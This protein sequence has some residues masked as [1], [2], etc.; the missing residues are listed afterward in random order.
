MSLAD[1]QPRLGKPVRWL[2]SRIWWLEHAFERARAAGRAEDDTRLRIFFVLALFAAGFLTLG[3]GAVH[4]ALFSDALHTSGYVAEQGAR[5]D[6]VDRNGNLLAVDLLHYGLFLDPKEIWDKNETRAALT[7]A[8]PGVT[9]DRLEKILAGERRTRLVGGLTPDDRTRINDLGLPGVSFEEEQAR[10]YP[11][12]ST[13]SHLIGF[14]DKGGDPLAGAEKAL[15]KSIRSGA[16]SGQPTVLSIDLRVQAALEDEVQKAAVEFQAKGAVGL[17]VNVHTGEILGIASYPDFDPNHAGQ[18]TPDQLMNRAAASVFE[19]GST[20]KAFTVATGL[21][22]GVATPE[23][24]FDATHPF[25]LGYRSIKDY[26]ATGAMLSLVDVFTHSSNIGTARLAVSIGPQRLEHYFDAFGLT[27]AADVELLE[28]R[29]PLTP[30]VWDE[31]AM[32]STSFG[33][34]MLVSPLTL[35]EAYCTVTNGGVRVPLTILKRTAPGWPMGVRVLK[36]STSLQMLQIMR[37]NVTHGTGGK[38]DAAGLTVGG[39]TGTGE[40]FLN[41]HY[42]HQKQVSSFAAVFP[43]EGGQKQDRYFVLVLMDEPKGNAASG[44]FATGGWV[45]APAA[46]RVID[47]IA[48]FLGVRRSSFSTP[49]LP[50][51]AVPEEVEAPTDVEA[52]H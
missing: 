43:T 30:R 29:R 21:D 16:D 17:V 47:R 13:A 8:L 27:K 10:L 50:A 6:I 15:D 22:T 14:T 28:T 5:A 51:K 41:G 1:F 52:G 48:P 26:H 32:A 40:K 18:A 12:G 35:A 31:D 11:L 44:G 42:D 38:A 36:E 2:G 20:F 45:A 39:K 49:G 9:L 34:G 46:G 3:L 23:T 37:A 25:Q 4:A 24:M 19:M 7:K 33:H